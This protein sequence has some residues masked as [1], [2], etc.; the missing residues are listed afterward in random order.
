MSKKSRFG[1][2]LFDIL[3]AIVAGFI[4]DDPLAGGII[5]ADTG[6]IDAEAAGTCGVYVVVRR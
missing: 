4:R 2:W 3:T 5:F 6:G 1:L